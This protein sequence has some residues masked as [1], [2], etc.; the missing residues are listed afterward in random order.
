MLKYVTPSILDKNLI[1]LNFNP[2]SKW[3]PYIGDSQ[4]GWIRRRASQVKPLKWMPMIP[5]IPWGVIYPW[6]KGIMGI[7][8]RFM[9]AKLTKKSLAKLGLMEDI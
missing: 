9:I 7:D 4:S 3:K 5:A 1:Q 8:M 2:F 6:N